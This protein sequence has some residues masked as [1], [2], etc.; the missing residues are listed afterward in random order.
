MFT[1]T[2]ATVALAAAI[3]APS[4]MA[5]KFLVNV[6]ETVTL[7]LNAPADSI[8]IGNATVVDVAVHDPLTLLVTGKTF[9]STNLMVLDKN[10][11]HVYNNTVA[12]KSGD[13]DQLTIIRGGGSFTYSCVDKCRAT[14]MVGDDPGHFGQVMATVDGKNAAARGQ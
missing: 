3:V 9:G 10:G 6:D 5:E 4:A 11:R 7:K 13:N 12:V 2:L 8:V 1:R 14:P